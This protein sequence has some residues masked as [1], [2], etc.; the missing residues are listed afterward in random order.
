MAGSSDGALLALSH[1]ER[2]ANVPSCT[3][4][5]LDRGAVAVLRRL[6][7]E[8]LKSTVDSLIEKISTRHDEIMGKE[9]RDSAVALGFLVT[10]LLNMLENP[11]ACTVKAVNEVAIGLLGAGTPSERSMTAFFPDISDQSGSSSAVSYTAGEHS[12]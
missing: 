10:Q 9:K 11:A 5:L 1:L 8:S 12:A 7:R 4:L 2:I 6:N 3:Q